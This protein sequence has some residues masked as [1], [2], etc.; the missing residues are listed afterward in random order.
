MSHRRIK[1]T[2]QEI[3]KH[4][5]ARGTYP[6]GHL[7][8][9]DEGALDMAIAVDP[10]TRTVLVDFGNPVAWF[11]MPPDKARE[12]GM[13]LIDRADEADKLPMPEGMPN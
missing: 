12:L 4:I 2:R 13:V 10:E 11:A 8:Q 7:G 3:Q 1:L 9:S 5:G 6:R